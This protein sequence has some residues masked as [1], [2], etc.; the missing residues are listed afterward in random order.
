[1]PANLQALIRYNV[2]DKCL[3]DTSRIWQ[4]KD[5]AVAVSDAIKDQKN[6]V[7]FPSKRTI[8]GDIA[9][10][11]SGELGYTAP[12]IHDRT[13]GYTYANPRFSIHHIS[14]PASLIHDLREGIAIIQQVTKNEKL[15]RISSSLTKICDY[16]HITYENPYNQHIYLEHSLNEP[17]QKWLDRVYEFTYDK[18]SMR[19]LYQPF[20]Q[21]ERTHFLSPAFIKEYN[22]RWYIF[23]FDFDLQKIVNLAMDRII[24]IQPS[25]RPYYIPENF[26]HDLHFRYLY[27]VTIPD[28]ADP[29]VI[30]FSASISLS[31]YMDTKPI[32][33]SQRKIS[34]SE[35]D[36]TYELTVYDN[37]EIRSKLRS[38]GSEIQII[39]PESIKN[40]MKYPS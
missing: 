20:G 33:M 40:E 22:N 21:E 31:H 11:R 37:Y 34:K 16:M 8:M 18:K 23:G 35:K 27:G 9:T 6:I 32:H 3:R 38:F 5:L 2:I 24:E 15:L 36:A 12:I 13:S 7:K 14:L 30:R 28:D 29:V 19:L 17:G 1:M 26:S 25:L 4:W 39:S 10:M